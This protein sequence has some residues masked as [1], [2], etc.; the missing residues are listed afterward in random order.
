MIFLAR[1][2]HENFHKTHSVLVYSLWFACVSSTGLHR[3]VAQH[4]GQAPREDAQSAVQAKASEK[5]GARGA[6][7]RSDL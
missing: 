4:T 6:I 5:R 7:F 1:N 2:I 3:A